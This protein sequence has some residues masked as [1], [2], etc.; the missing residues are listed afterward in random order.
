M[1]D[2]LIRVQ[3]K[4]MPHLDNREAVL[5]M[6]EAEDFNILGVGVSRVGIAVDTETVAKLAWRSRGLT[7]NLIEHRL[8]EYVEKTNTSIQPDALS[9]E[10]EIFLKDLLAP[11][12]DYREDVLWMQRC[13]QVNY[14]IT[15]HKMK[16]L[17]QD[18]TRFG[19]TDSAVNMGLLSTELVC[20]DYCYISERLYD[21]VMG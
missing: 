12:K 15:D 16:R 21:E 17:A 20:F 6:I 11:V 5:D 9:S 4:I 13:I 14:Q 1:K 18:L 8:W 3:K 19:I 2:E 10:P 7:D